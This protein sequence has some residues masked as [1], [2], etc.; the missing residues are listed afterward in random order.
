MS[1]LKPQVFEHGISSTSR[2]IDGDCSENGSKGGLQVHRLA[3]LL[4]SRSLQVNQ[5]RFLSTCNPLPAERSVKTDTACSIS[6][7]MSLPS[8]SA[9]NQVNP[10][11]RREVRV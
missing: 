11:A 6:T 2:A 9:V 5:L 8:V 1:W 4:R 7:V 10:T 3:A